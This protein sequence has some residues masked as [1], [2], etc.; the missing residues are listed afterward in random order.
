M[1]A[2]DECVNQQVEKLVGGLAVDALRGIRHGR[3][4]GGS[5]TRLAWLDAEDMGITDEPTGQ[6]APREP[7]R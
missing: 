5:I 3:A 2:A 6:R 1:A 4:T 7:R